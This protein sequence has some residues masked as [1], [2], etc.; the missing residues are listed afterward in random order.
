MKS[1]QT[2]LLL[3]TMCLGPNALYPLDP[4]LLKPLKAPSCSAANLCPHSRNT[5]SLYG[6]PG[7]FFFPQMGHSLSENTMPFPEPLSDVPNKPAKSLELCFYIHSCALR[8]NRICQDRHTI[9]LQ[10]KYLIQRMF[11]SMSRVPTWD[12]S[13]RCWSHAT[14]TANTHIQEHKCCYVEAAIFN[15]V[16]QWKSDG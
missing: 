9:M 8:F 5:G 11:P 1:Q 16:N 15:S 14:E 2:P 7:S 10:N 12:L 13:H 3:S 6:Q 4:L